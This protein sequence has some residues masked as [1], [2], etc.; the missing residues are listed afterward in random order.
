MYVKSDK[1]RYLQGGKGRP[2]RC[3]CVY[4]VDISNNWELFSKYIYVLHL[5]PQSNSDIFWVCIF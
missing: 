2:G 3:V 4:K 5:D 1:G